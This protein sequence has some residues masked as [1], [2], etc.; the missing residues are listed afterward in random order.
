MGQTAFFW[1]VVKVSDICYT[2]T[3]LFEIRGSDCVKETIAIAMS[4]G[5]DSSVAAYLLQQQGYHGTGVTLRLFDMNDL[6]PGQAEHCKALHDLSDAKVV[7]A[8]LGMEHHTL[9]VT[10]EFRTQVMNDFIRAYEQGKTPNPCVVCNRTIKFGRMLELVQELGCSLLATGH[11]AQLER[12]AN[13]RILLKR[14]KHPEKDQSYV[15]WSLSQQQ[16]SHVRLP[17]GGLSKEEIRTI[18]Q[19]QGLVSAKKRDSQDICFVPDGDYVSFIR[20]RT[21]KTYPEGQFC[22]SHG[23][24]LGTHRGIIEYT[25][26]Q[27]RGLGVS[28]NQGRLYVNRVVPE[29]NQVILSDNAALFHNG[30]TANQLNLI[31]M[32]KLDAPLRVQAKVRYRMEPQPAT[33][34]QTG[35]DTAQV[36]FDKPQRAITPGQSVVFYDGDYVVGGATILEGADV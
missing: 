16:F 19:E 2:Q 22:D 32:D 24:V 4:G 17:L 7:A 15:L 5:V 9:D 13:G 35:E 3:K 23:T 8:H 10:E 11:Y 34:I 25:V 12:D 1:L 27:R 36:I 26:G 30:L 29:T 6:A 33:L 14:A 20:H 21:Q 28:S 31:P 18:A